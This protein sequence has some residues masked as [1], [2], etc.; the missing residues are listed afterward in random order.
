[1]PAKKAQ[2]TVIDEESV[3]SI[4]TLIS[5]A[6]TGLSDVWEPSLDTIA[7]LD[8]D[9]IELT[10]HE[11]VNGIL[12]GIREKL[13]PIYSIIP[14]E[15]A[16]CWSTKWIKDHPALADRVHK[17]YKERFER[18]E[19]QHQVAEL[20]LQ[21]QCP[22]LYAVAN[23]EGH[24][25][26]IDWSNMRQRLSQDYT[27]TEGKDWFVKMQDLLLNKLNKRTKSR[28]RYIIGENGDLLLRDGATDQTSNPNINAEQI[29]IDD[30]DDDD[31]D[32][33]KHK[34]GKQDSA[35]VPSKTASRSRR[36]ASTS[37]KTAF[38]PGGTAS[39]SSKTASSM[40]E[41]VLTTS[42]TTPP[43]T[44]KRGGKALQNVALKKKPK[45][46]NDVL[47]G[48]DNDIA[49]SELSGRRL[50]AMI[51][52]LDALDQK[53][54]DLGAE[55]DACFKVGQ[56]STEV[57][58]SKCALL[59]ECTDKAVA[60]TKDLRVQRVKAET[61][62]KNFHECYVRAYLATHQQYLERTRL[63]FSSAWWQQG[64]DKKSDEEQE[65]ALQNYYDSTHPY[66]MLIRKLKGVSYL[67][68]VEPHVT[69]DGSGLLSLE[70][71]NRRMS[72]LFGV[73]GDK[74]LQ[75]TSL[76][77]LP[78]ILQDKLVQ[79]GE[80]PEDGICPA[81]LLSDDLADQ[82]RKSRSSS[83]DLHSIPA[84]LMS[85]NTGVLTPGVIEVDDDHDGDSADQDGGSAVQD[86]S[87]AVQGERTR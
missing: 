74:T 37:P 31:D 11:N 57:V 72:C 38:T 23:E 1:M 45:V 43:L 8:P 86:A 67:S 35:V 61:D 41:T 10:T 68:P 30:N 34:T 6:K 9:N 54:I 66:C 64:L 58:Q 29:V 49:A 62:K 36:M 27:T 71:T 21:H 44:R 55:I 19:L 63:L 20:N 39:M 73:G 87:V 32:D 53:S 84:I 79:E 50:D 2:E 7:A 22:M 13:N 81:N 65:Q 48:K 33:E 5:T 70:E 76:L 69:I 14:F 17:A 24:L 83:S 47:D 3:D 85:A 59:K 56:R 78:S 52:E 25:G 40:S 26:A 46:T 18:L 77:Q 16:K 82:I 15:V 51:V 42:G 75:G 12:T 80:W 4:E 60:M 28:N